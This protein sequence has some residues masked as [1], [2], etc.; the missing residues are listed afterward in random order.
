M[1]KLLL[2]IIEKTPFGVK[3]TLTPLWPALLRYFTTE[4]EELNYSMPLGL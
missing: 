3:V 1:Q 4:K 2:L